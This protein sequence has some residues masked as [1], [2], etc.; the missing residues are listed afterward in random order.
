MAIPIVLGWGCKKKYPA[1]MQKA[2]FKRNITAVY[3][4]ILKISLVSNS[5]SMIKMLTYLSLP[6]FYAIKLTNCDGASAA[7]HASLQ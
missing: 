2:K 1:G 6:V 4:S 7:G 5:V 3:L